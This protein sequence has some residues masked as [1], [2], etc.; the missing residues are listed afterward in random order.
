M[1]R[2]SIVF[3]AILL[4]LFAWSAVSVRRAASAARRAEAAQHTLALARAEAATLLKLR[5]SVP[6]VGTQAGEEIVSSVRRAAR[7]AGLRDDTV[8]EIAPESDVV[9][10]SG[11]GRPGTRRH[12]A[13]VLLADVSARDLGEFLAAWTHVAPGWRV[14]AIQFERRAAPG[15][16]PARGFAARL[17][18]NASGPTEVSP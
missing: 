15:P 6:R 17:T 5:A 4:V 16:D 10:D 18:V 7:D 1:K 12:T 14:T 2:S 11:P 9:A 3:V 8:R 13:R